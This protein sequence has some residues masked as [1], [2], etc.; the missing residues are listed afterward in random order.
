MV[1]ASTGLIQRPIKAEHKS[2]DHSVPSDHSL[3]AATVTMQGKEHFTQTNN[4][5]ATGFRFQFR[6]ATKEQWQEFTETTNTTLDDPDM[7]QLLGLPHPKD[8]RDQ[9]QQQQQL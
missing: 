7:F 1:F 3:V 6:D 2:L 4:K 8:H 5:K 9:E